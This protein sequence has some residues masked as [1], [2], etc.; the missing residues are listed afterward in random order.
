[1]MTQGKQS[2]ALSFSTYWIRRM[3]VHS[4]EHVDMDTLCCKFVDR[5][6]PAVMS[7]SSLFN[8]YV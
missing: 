6:K 7:V 2:A 1:M 4:T 5:A 3:R 8:R